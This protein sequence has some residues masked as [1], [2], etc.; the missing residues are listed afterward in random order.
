MLLCLILLELLPVAVVFGLASLAR[1]RRSRL[2]RLAWLGLARLGRRHWTAIA[3]VVGLSLAQSAVVTWL[4]RPVPKVHDEFAYLLAADTFAHGRLTNPPVE[5]WPHLETYHV[6][7]QPTY[8]SKYP[9]AQGFFLAIGQVLTGV[10]VVGVW[11][12]M[13][14]AA[15]A[16]CWMLQGWLPGRWALLGA[17]LML[18]H[19]KIQFF[20]GQNYW[21]GQVA[22]LGG[23]LLLGAVPRLLR[24]PCWSVGTTAAIGVALLAFSRPYE[25]ACASLIPCAVI[26]AAGWRSR[27]RSLRAG[28]RH[29]F[30]AVSVVMIL[31]VAMMAYYNR[32]V[33]GSPWQMPYELHQKQYFPTPVFLWQSPSGRPQYR[34]VEMRAFYEVYAADPYFQ[35][36]SLRG[37][38][39]FRQM[40]LLGMWYFFLRPAA[41]LPLVLIGRCLRRE[42]RLWIAV[43]CFATCLAG[44][45][46]VPWLQPHYLAPAV[47]AMFLL[48]V[49]CMR[50]M[51]GWGVVAGVSGRS[52]LIGWLA[53]Y[54]V[55]FVLGARGELRDS[56]PNPWYRDREK[57]KQMLAEQPGKHLVVVQYAPDHSVLDEWVFNGADVNSAKIVWAR[58]MGPKE[59]EKLFRYFSYRRIWVLQ[60]D[61]LPRQ[62]AEFRWAAGNGKPDAVPSPAPGPSPDSRPHPRTLTQRGAAAD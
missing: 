8:T 45:F 61:V 29:M 15:G 3:V 37:Y 51:R 24:R 48:L 60:A 53:I 10:P 13:A 36:Q 19:A 40:Y 47:P 26:L 27:E 12:A 22:F 62:L 38:L 50:Q 58:N 43:G 41:A 11:L 14:L 39:Q 9:P 7:Q 32:S 25:G 44:S 33:T 16:L 1:G 6:L 21:G 35:Q 31:C 2:A 28:Q 52:A 18:L 30:A 20:W 49:A 54:V 57:L 17:L 56:E 59:N 42:P 4:H 5:V 23:A 55:L 46:A 34:H